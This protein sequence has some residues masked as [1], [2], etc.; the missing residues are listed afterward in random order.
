M[1]GS[2]LLGGLG[3]TSPQPSIVGSHINKQSLQYIIE[4]Y[5]NG[6]QVRMTTTTFQ[7]SINDMNALLLINRMDG[8]ILIHQ[9]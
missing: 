4:I 1:S 3:T 6:N 8:W 9:I 7:L 2:R 5:C